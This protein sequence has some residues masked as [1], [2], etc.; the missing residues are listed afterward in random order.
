MGRSIWYTFD[1]MDRPS[2]PE[3]RRQK[4]PRGFTRPEIEAE[5]QKA[6]DAVQR[7][8]N[9]DTARAKFLDKAKNRLGRLF[10]GSDEPFAPTYAKI[11]SLLN[12]NDPRFASEVGGDIAELFEKIYEDTEKVARLRANEREERLLSIEHGGSVSLSPEAVLYGN[13][14]GDER[15]FHLHVGASRTMSPAELLADIRAGMRELARKLQHD[16]A[17]AMVDTV[18]GTSWIVGANPKLLAL[19]GFSVEAEP[20][21]AERAAA[22]FGGE[23]R[24]IKRATIS[25]DALIAKF[26]EKKSP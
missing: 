8:G 23:T 22:H 13:R 11:E 16:P 19:M 18:V 2:N 6:F 12:A 5:M 4:I 7:A 14:H 25:R 24:V 21:S 17:F 26:G 3:Q 9:P 15:S 20:I 10:D 1:R